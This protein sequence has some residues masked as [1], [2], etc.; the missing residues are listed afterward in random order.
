MKKKRTF[1]LYLVSA[2]APRASRA[3]ATLSPCTAPVDTFGY[4]NMAYEH[5]FQVGVSCYEVALPKALVRQAFKQCCAKWTRW[6]VQMWQVR[7]F[8]QGLRGMFDTGQAP[9]LAPAG[10][11]WPQPEP[12]WS[13]VVCA[14]RDG[15]VEL[16]LV[17]EARRTFWSEEHEEFVLPVNDGRLNRGWFKAMGFDVLDMYPSMVVREAPARP[18][19]RL[20][21]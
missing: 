9:C 8:I 20:V 6:P 10:Y 18:Y 14:F 7:A 12:G 11:Q 16:D 3:P 19:L 15:H 2:P 21:P 13:L 5:F 17:H 1:P 4:P